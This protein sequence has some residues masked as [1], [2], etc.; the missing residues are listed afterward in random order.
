PWTDLFSQFQIAKATKLNVNDPAYY[1]ELAKI[2]KTE[3]P[4]TIRD[5]LVWTVLRESA[6]ELGKAW[7]DEDFVMKKEL[8]GV[9][10][11]APRWRR[12]VHHVDGE[13]GELLAQSY[14]QARFAGDSKS[15]AVEL[16]K[17]VLAAM[18]VE[19]D[20]LAWMDQPTRDAAKKKLGKMGY[21]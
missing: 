8:Q 12:C 15:R 4:A 10:E 1:V 9:K 20:Q 5:Y 3:K 17:T 14:V 11:L 13:L 7:V 18:G 19:L 2:W 6:S 16:T 21:L